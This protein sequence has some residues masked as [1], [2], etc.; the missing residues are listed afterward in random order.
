M[1]HP[2]VGVD[3]ANAL[4]KHD[5]D[6][7]L[8][9]VSGAKTVTGNYWWTFWIGGYLNETDSK[10]YWVDGSE[11]GTSGYSNW[12]DGQPDN[13]NGNET[14]MDMAGD[15]DN[16]LPL[17]TWNDDV[18]TQ[19]LSYFCEKPAAGTYMVVGRPNKCQ[20]KLNY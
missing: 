2:V 20:L 5:D 3:N 19:V 18:R 11:V 7:D 10:W 6:D 17:G 16:W 8:I 15:A 14:V 12:A 13:T 9:F 1:N 4:P